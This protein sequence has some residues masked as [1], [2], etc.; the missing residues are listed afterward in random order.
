MTLIYRVEHDEYKHGP[1]RD[2]DYA[3][4]HGQPNRPEHPDPEDDFDTDAWDDRSYVFAFASLRQLRDWFKPAEL[5]RMRRRD[6]IVR[7][8]DVPAGEIIVGRS[9]VAFPG[10]RKS[11]PHGPLFML[12][13][14]T[15][16]EKK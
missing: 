6:F 16:G 14:R 7:Y 5:R 10:N 3:L 11:Y 8:Y 4:W 2:H 13:L 15:H 1:Y 9:Q 12:R